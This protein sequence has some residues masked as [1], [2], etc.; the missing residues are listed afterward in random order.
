MRRKAEEKLHNHQPGF[1]GTIKT[2]K[3]GGKMGIEIIQTK[4]E[5]IFV[6][7][8][9]GKE[10]VIYHSAIGEC[11]CGRQVTLS[12]FTNECDCGIDYNF[13][14]QKLAPREQWGEETGEHWSEC[15]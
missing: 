12:S 1:T 14:G 3:T 9:T 6:D 2:L 4:H 7:P 13:A 10:S 11:S 8:E 15:Y 5:E